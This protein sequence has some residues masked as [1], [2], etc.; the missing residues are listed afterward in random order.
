MRR[1]L[2]NRLVLISATVAG[3]SLERELYS[4]A[5]C[6]RDLASLILLA[7][8]VGTASENSSKDTGD[9]RSYGKTLLR[10]R[11][12]YGHSQEE[13]GAE[14]GGIT[15]SEVSLYES[16]RRRPRGLKRQKCDSYIKKAPRPDPSK[17]VSP[18]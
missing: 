9:F 5:D 4:I 7:T 3:H 10:S 6:S 13:A 12:A 17:I 14:M 2:C 8:S 15:Q 16:G 1:F 18:Q 11:S